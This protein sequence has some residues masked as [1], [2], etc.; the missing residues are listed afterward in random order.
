MGALCGRGSIMQVRGWRSGKI[1]LTM[2]LVVFWAGCT[3]GS[4]KSGPPPDQSVPLTIPSTPPPSASEGT[5]Y[6]Y[7]IL[8]S[9][10]ATVPLA[11]GP[12]G[13]TISNGT[14]TWTPT[15]AQARIANSFTITATAG[16]QSAPQNW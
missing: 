16:S 5:A 14:L 6:S 12:T 11:S 13:A 4:R 2:S 7:V 9:T 8:T 15:S 1:L 10:P 3:G